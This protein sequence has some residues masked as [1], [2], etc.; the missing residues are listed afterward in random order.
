[1]VHLPTL[2]VF[3]KTGQSVGSFET[4]VLDE[5]GAHDSRVIAGL[6]GM[7]KILGYAEFELRA[8]S[9][10]LLALCSWRGS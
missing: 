10:F 3:G 4:E 7:N 8:V 5:S 6:W 1:S 9:D 2:M